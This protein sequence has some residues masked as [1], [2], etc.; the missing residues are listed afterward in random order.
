MTLKQL[1]SI[2]DQVRIYKTPESVQWAIDHNVSKCCGVT[3]ESIPNQT[4]SDQF[5][6]AACGKTTSPIS[7]I[8]YR[9]PTDYIDT[10]R[11]DSD[12][13]GDDDD[14]R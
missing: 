2:I 6:C 5:I 14:D 9:N 4:R 12:I 7:E 13:E 3:L 1:A 11:F 10:R 8:C